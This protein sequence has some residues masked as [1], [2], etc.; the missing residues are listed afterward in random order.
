MGKHI[1]E[2]GTWNMRKEKRDD[3]NKNNRYGMMRI[4]LT[5]AVV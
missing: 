2:M 3:K 1:W 4:R 5:T